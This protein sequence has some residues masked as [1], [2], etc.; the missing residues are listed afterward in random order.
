MSSSVPP[1]FPPPNQ[2]PLP[3][4]KKPNILLWILGGFVVLMIGVTA[5]CGLGGYFLMRK[6]KQA[7]FDSDLLT[8]NPAYA[9]AKM[10][11]TLNPDVETVTSDDG[12]GT[13]TWTW[14][15]SREKP[16]PDYD[17]VIEEARKAVG[18]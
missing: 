10:A 7:G 6:A 11:V 14:I 5:M 12:S 9:A 8:K 3:P 1:P 17:L 13:I 4:G 2:A 16:Q 15:T 18:S